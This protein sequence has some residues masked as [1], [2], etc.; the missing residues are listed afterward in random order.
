MKRKIS[1]L[2]LVLPL[3]FAMSGC[4][5]YALSPVLGAIYTDVKAPMGVTSNVGASKVGE[6]SATSIL[7]LI[8]T[9]DASIQAAMKQGGITKVQHV[10]YNTTSVLGIYATYTVTVYGE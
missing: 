4:A 9:G 10:D 5:A 1:W 6:A 2:A 8:A 7:G 3:A